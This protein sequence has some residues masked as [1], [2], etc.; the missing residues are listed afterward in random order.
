[1]TH[2]LQ[3]SVTTPWGLST[4]PNTVK[5]VVY[6]N[7]VW[8]SLPRN[9]PTSYHMYRGASSTSAREI[10]GAKRRIA[11]QGADDFTGT[12]SSTLGGWPSLYNAAYSK[13]A[14][15]AKGGSAQVGVL[16]GEWK[17][18]FGM[19][20]NRLQD[21]AEL[22][23]AV[24]RMNFRKI[25]RLLKR[26]VKW[27]KR[28]I[29]RVKRNK[30]NSVA[31]LGDL[32]LEWAFGWSPMIADVGAA[33][34]VL[35]QPGPQSYSVKRSRSAPKSIVPSGGYQY[36]RRTDHCNATVHV[37]CRI[38]ITNP[39]AFLA[40]RLGIADVAGIAWELTP[41]SFLVDWVADVGTFIGSF[42]DFV[43]ME[44]SGK[45]AGIKTTHK[46]TIT[47][48]MFYTGKTDIRWIVYRRNLGHP[49]PLPNFEFS[50]NLGTSITR[51]ANAAA[52]LA[53][54]LGRLRSSSIAHVL[55]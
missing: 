51:A 53:Q 34:D 35:S 7:G 8:L 13:M 10:N 55:V 32:W 11:L 47:Y 15:A 5:D 31:T 43:G 50:A 14:E 44:A 48:Q 12:V 24:Y 33:M 25:G 54:R 4:S 27:V 40:N 19:M 52:L 21:V 41:F 22:A 3:S 49:R 46:F 30:G 20:A 9:T 36:I 39:N 38:D 26:S 23:H 16:F 28:S 2:P 18:S 37:G 17:Q 6:K 45:W 42:T 29:R 1:M